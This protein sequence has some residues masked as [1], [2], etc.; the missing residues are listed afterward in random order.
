MYIY[1]YTYL[2]IHDIVY[3]VVKIYTLEAFW[4]NLC[5]EVS[6]LLIQLLAFGTRL[7]FFWR[8]SGTITSSGKKLER[9]SFVTSAWIIYSSKVVAGYPRR[10]R[11]V[12]QR[13]LYIS[14]LAQHSCLPERC[15]W[16]KLWQRKQI[17]AACGSWADG[18]PV[19]FDVE[20]VQVSGEAL[21]SEMVGRTW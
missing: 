19:W 16:N 8:Y 12:K 2:Y 13:K 3:A 18:C 15:K 21:S 20:H 1:M 11:L 5:E 7:E 6:F 14:R 17:F 10:S 4:P 9:P